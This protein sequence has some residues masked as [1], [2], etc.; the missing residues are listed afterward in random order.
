[1]SVA[2]LILTVLVVSTL[3][4]GLGWAL[5]V[6][7]QMRERYKPIVDLQA[8]ESRL[9]KTVTEQRLSWQTEFEKATGEL[10]ALLDQV[11]HVSDQID[12]ESH[13]LY[14]PRYDFATAALYKARLDDI[15]ERQKGM[16]RNGIAATSSM[17][18]LVDGSASKGRQVQ[19]RQLKL[20]LRAFNGEC[21][22]AIAKVKFNNVRAIEDRIVKAY[23]AINK[24][25]EPSHCSISGEYM[26]LKV[27]ELHL[28][29][30][31]Q[32]RRKAEQ[33][34]QRRIREQMREEERARR[35]IEKAQADAER[36]EQ[37]SQ[38]ALERARA[39]LQ[40]ASESQQA[41]LR[42][43]IAALETQLAEAQANKERAISRAQMTRSGH[44]Y[45]ISNIGS[46]GENVFKIGMT[47]RLEPM[48]RVQE[49]GDASVP[50]PFDVHAMIFSQDAP[51]LEAELHRKFSDHQVNLV[52][53]RKE[54]FSIGAEELAS[55]VQRLN[56]SIEFTL[57][58]EAEQYRQTVAIRK[59]NQ[60]RDRVDDAA[61]AVDIAA[62]DATRWRVIGIDRETGIDT[63]QVVE[64]QTE[65]DAVRQ[66][67]TNG[68]AVSAVVRI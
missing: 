45:V 34:E 35:E 63:S 1:M 46:F 57:V 4:V 29:H 62:N 26:S 8:E 18:W 28:A 12:I 52:N 7:W 37:R 6:I 65:D 9:R 14:E 3:L 33:E 38:E 55:E 30:E 10:N 50:F 54:F 31:Y 15:R 47:R 41:K 13:G 42:D 66:A 20:M 68:M 19:K 16:T 24:I 59:A 17:E 39:E 11:D 43:K 48:D 5:V 23:S 61:A 53:S 51:G 56:G 60:G 21:D 58:A 67:G 27:E 2:M 25:G 22:S 64:A 49:L 36:E 40:R 44:V 32:E